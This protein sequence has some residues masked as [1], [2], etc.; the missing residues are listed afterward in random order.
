[1]GH[2]GILNPAERV[3]LLAGEVIVMSPIGHRHAACVDRLNSAFAAQSARLA[4]RALVRVQS[5]LAE[6]EIS[7]P[8]PDL[9][10]LAHRDDRYDFGHPQPQDVLL[11]VEAAESSINYDRH[12]KLPFYAAAGIRE[13]WIVNLQADR[14]ESYTEPEAG[15]YR[16][17]RGY[18]LG[19]RL[20]PA[21]LPDLQLAVAQIIPARA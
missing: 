2:T 1:M 3:E 19:D 6:S 11:L 4:G 5:P 9:M 17:T 10:L 14:I 15:G 20:A 21:A 16:V 7:E 13:V 18:G 12:T 8:Q